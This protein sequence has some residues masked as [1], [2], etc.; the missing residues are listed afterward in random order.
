MTEIS[1]DNNNHDIT[2]QVTSQSLHAVG[3][4]ITVIAEDGDTITER[5]TGDTKEKNPFMH[6]L[7]KAASQYEG[8]Y[9]GGTFTV[10]SPDGTDYDYSILYELTQKQITLEPAIELSGST[11]QGENSCTG[12]FHI[13]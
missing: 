5:F 6:K 9:I 7:E 8:C 1:I 11:T 4:E 12:T 2:V 10:N 3:F 13:N